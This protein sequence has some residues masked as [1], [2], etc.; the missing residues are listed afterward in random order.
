MLKHAVSIALIVDLCG[1]SF[2]RA[3]E[4]PIRQVVLYKHGVGYFERSGTI[5]AGDTAQFDFR[6]AEMNDVLKSLTINGR[7]A[8]VTGL[9]YDS[10]VPLEVKLADFPFRIDGGSPLSG[11]LDQ[12]KGARVEMQVGSEKVAGAIVA[13]RVVAGDKDRPERQQI[14]LLMDSGEMRAFDLDAATSMR[15]ADAKLQTQFRDYLG[16]LQSARSKEKRSVYL[17]AN[18]SGARDI[19]AEYIIPMP[20]WKS[21]YRLLFADGGEP[22]LEG[23]A[24]VDN[25]TDE[26]WTNVQMAL[27]SGKPISFVSELYAPRYIRRET[28]ELPEEAAVRPELHQGAI[29]GAIGSTAVDGQV[30]SGANMFRAGA[31]LGHGFGSGAFK[32]A[33]PPPAD[34]AQA[35][36]VSAEASSIAEAANGAEIADLFEYRIAHPVTIKRNESAMLPFLQDKIKARKVVLYTGEDALHP[37][38]AAELTNSTGKTLDGGPITVFD[39]GAYAGEALVETVKSGDKRLVS[40]GVDLGTRVSSNIDSF[41]QRV[42]EIHIHRGVMTT[43]TSTVKKT[44]YTINNV[45]AKP[46]T[47]ILEHELTPT[48]KILNQKPIEVTGRASRFEVQLQPAASQIFPVIEEQVLNNELAVSNQ[49]IDSILE[50]ERNKALTDAGRRAIE[51]LAALKRQIAEN[52][53]QAKR[54]KDRIDTIAVDEERIRKNLESLNRVSGQQDLV[55]KYAGQLALVETEMAGLRDQQGTLARKSTELTAAIDDEIEKMDF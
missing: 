14:V 8:N 39:A 18:A 25:T 36:M 47:L 19:T 29:A 2:C 12:L 33:P 28:A 9:R 22:T 6:A 41:E 55:Q 23:W 53:E 49:N 13:A 34:Q 17:D 7:S 21:S 37:L 16:A 44:T 42:I 26:D 43:R 10:S 51:E 31:G 46:K 54:V 45:D 3:A 50:Y 4:V 15:F 30:A 40:Y 52:G 32:A 38:N 24:I 27:V 11:V 48:F 20:I 35:V 5:P 1:A